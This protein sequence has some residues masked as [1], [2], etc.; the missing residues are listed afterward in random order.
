MSKTKTSKKSST[1]EIEK[2]VTKKPKKEKESS[3]RYNSGCDLIDLAVGGGQGLGYPAG[4]IINIV[5]DKSAGKSFVAAELL[6]CAYYQ[7]KK[8]LKWIYDDAESGFTFDTKSLY[9]F[10]IIPKEGNNTVSE[11]VEDLYCNVRKFLES[12][13][14]DQ[15]GIYII[16]SLDGL[17]SKELQEISDKRYT[18][19]K[20]GEKFDKG[21]YK[22]AMAKFLSQEFFRG[23]AGLIHEKNALLIIISQIRYDIDPMSFKKYT[24]TGGKAMDHYCHSVLWLANVKKITKK[25]RVISVIIRVKLDKSKTPRPYRECM[26]PILFDYGIDNIGANIDFLFDI[27]S[28]AG[29][30]SKG[31]NSIVWD[32]QDPMKR[33][34]LIS[35]IEK[36]NL[37]QELSKRVFDKWEEIE[38]AIKIKRVSKYA[39]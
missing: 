21:S 3:V 5:G 9:G 17:S 30:L 29:E 6:A 19:W 27:R 16:D 38:T 2:A 10:D 28:K 35:Y 13:R 23:L 11:T 8:K 7:F 33:K 1:K 36:N 25:D 24:R 15:F 4:R 39:Q 18:K 14:N 31:S 26:F 20:K 32:K 22:M 12:L 37:Q 34:K